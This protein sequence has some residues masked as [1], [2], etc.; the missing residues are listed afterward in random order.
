M[1]DSEKT[2][3]IHDLND[4]DAQTRIVNPKPDTANNPINPPNEYRRAAIPATRLVARPTLPINQDPPINEDTRPIAG[5]LVV[6]SGP[7]RGKYAPIFD[8]MNSIGRDPDQSTRLDFGDEMISRNGQ[9]FITYDVKDRVFYI[10]H[11]GKPNL[12]RLNGQ[13]VL[14]PNVLT[15]RDKIE[16]GKT[17]LQFIPFCGADFDWQDEA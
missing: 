8:N 17:T 9:A 10:S 16:I 1:T 15:A 12:V 6:I 13:V 3:L 5:W 11:G 4:E 2:R 14:Q 7:G